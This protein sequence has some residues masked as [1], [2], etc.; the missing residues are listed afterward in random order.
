MT[1]EILLRRK[2][3]EKGLKINFIANELGLSTYGLMLKIQNKSEF[4]T[5]EVNGLCEIL[6]IDSLEEKE[7]IFFKK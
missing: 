7:T 5:S 1:D 2:I 4:K 6:G 3:K